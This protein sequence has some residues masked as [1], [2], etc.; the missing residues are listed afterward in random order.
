M[1]TIVEHIRCRSLWII[2][3]RARKT[4]R[5]CC[6]RHRRSFRTG[7]GGLSPQTLD[8]GQYFFQN[9][10]TTCRLPWY[11]IISKFITFII[12]QVCMLDDW[13]HWYVPNSIACSSLQSIQVGTFQCAYTSSV[14]L[15]KGLLSKFAKL[16][17]SQ[18]L[19]SNKRTRGPD[20]PQYRWYCRQFGKLILSSAG[21]FVISL[22]LFVKIDLATDSGSEYDRDKKKIGF[23]FFLHV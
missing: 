20:L 7:D 13:I 8:H 5:N 16:T 3:S 17:I 19:A 18:N 10:V 23:H 21:P 15:I 4:R 9:G 12:R 6:R 14:I 11:I 1:A 2:A 22:F